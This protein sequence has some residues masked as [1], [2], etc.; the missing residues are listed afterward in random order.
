M[1]TIPEMHDDGEEGGIEIGKPSRS[2]LS[3]SQLALVRGLPAL[4]P[5]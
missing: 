3:P 2:W 4:C 1:A 5:S